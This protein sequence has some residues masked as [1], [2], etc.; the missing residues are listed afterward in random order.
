MK[1]NI[2]QI[3]CWHKFDTYKIGTNVP[4]LG[5]RVDYLIEECSKC[6]KQRVHFNV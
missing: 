2:K 6:G 3:L 1:L 5:I 4:I